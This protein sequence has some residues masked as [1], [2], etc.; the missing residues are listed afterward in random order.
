MPRWRRGRG[1][2]RVRGPG[3]PMTPRKI[4]FMPPIKNFVPAIPKD[5]I[6]EHSSKE[7]IFLT[8]A[9][10]EVLRLVDLQGLMQEEAGNQM[11]VSRGTIWRLLQSAREK[12][13]RMI[14]EGRELNI[15]PEA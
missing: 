11:G 5:T 6:K 3:R 9:E 14:V 1:K 12:V 7:P 4:N 8:Y 10:L 2:G 15:I 13:T